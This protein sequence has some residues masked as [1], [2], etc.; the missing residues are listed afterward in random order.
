MFKNKSR[1]NN[2]KGS[3]VYISQKSYDNPYFSSA[4]KKGVAHVAS[5][6]SLKTKIIFF[7]ILSAS[8]FF[9]WLFLYSKYFLIYDIDIN[10]EKVNDIGGLSESEIEKITREQLRSRYIFLPGNNIFLFKE[11][12]L[13]QKLNKDLA[14]ESINITKKLPNKLLIDIKEISYALI[15]KENNEFYYITINGEVISSVYEEDMKNIFPLIEN[16]G[17][18]LITE[19]SI[20]DKANHLRL[21]V[22]LYKDFKDTNILN[23]E[24]FILGNQNENTL[25]MKILD[26][27]EVYFSTINEVGPQKDNLL[28][29]KDGKLKNDL[30]SKSYVDLRYGDMIYY[31]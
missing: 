29:L 2:K 19:N 10:I 11:D 6:I 31:R 14:F 27:P 12:D 16:R 20:N 18:D 1:I 7:L 13:Y 30:Y 9:I 21:A 24:K 23:V 25:T 17:V 26:G 4:K 5:S 22:L 15:W 28:I 3:K 8:S